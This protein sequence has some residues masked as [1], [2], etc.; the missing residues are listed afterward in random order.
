MNAIRLLKLK[1][2]KKLKLYKNYIDSRLNEL[3]LELNNAKKRN[4]L[5]HVT[6]TVHVIYFNRD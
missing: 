3:K 4:E 5:K 6:V 1:Y 2:S